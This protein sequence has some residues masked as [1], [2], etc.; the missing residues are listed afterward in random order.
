MLPK[1]KFIH[2]TLQLFIFAVLVAPGC[3]KAVEVGVPPTNLVSA[4]VFSSNSTAIAAVTGMYQQ[5]V[6][7]SFAGNTSQGY[8]SLTSLA[9]LSA[10]EFALYSNA[11]SALQQAYS[12]SLKSNSSPFPLWSSL[13]NCIY[14]SNS[15]LA[16]LSSSTGVT[17]SV[18]S[19]LMGS[20][21]FIRAFCNFYLVNMFGD[22][23]LATSPNYATNN[24]TARTPKALVYQ[25][26]VID[27]S[28]AQSLLGGNFTSLSGTGTAERTLPTQGAAMGLLARTYLYLGKYDS[29]KTMATGVINN[30]SI[31]K[32]V[33]NPDSVFLKNS[34]EAIWQL[35]PVQTGY[36]TPDGYTYV[37]TAG[38]NTG[39]NPIYLSTQLLNAFELGDLRKTH[40]VA[41]YSATYSYAYKYKVKG[42]PANT[43][44]TEYYMVLRLAEQY[45]IRAE[46]E[47][48]LG[49]SVNAIL[50]LNVI[51]S[52][53]HL[54]AYTPTI[55]GPL[56]PAI[57]HERQVE[58]FAEWGHRWLDLNRTGAVNNV[59]G[60]PGNVCLAKGGT[61]SPNWSVYPV[62]FTD[63]SVDP[64][65][66]Q[67]NGYN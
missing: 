53:A 37:L 51:R 47:A 27:L 28:N 23:P 7:S 46:A 26:I 67:N 48:A 15:A 63:I 11:P 20:C 18:K 66:T 59:L 12:N 30:T 43:A 21:Y 54:T 5:V 56:L 24:A 34:T 16:G 9:G 65:L 49:D 36:N 45:L 55:N 22:V 44:I 40:W 8:Y 57:L 39:S 38:P 60:N 19:Q 61:W 33:L 50:D 62:P 35:P 42:G 2:I 32:L 25:Q 1:N 64:N 58:L 29:A 31:Y 10:D 41:T 13:Y 6:G 3:R 52:R 4:S 17:P 14:L